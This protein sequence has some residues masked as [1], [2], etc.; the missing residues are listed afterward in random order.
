MKINGRKL[1]FLFGSFIALIIVAL[2]VYRGGI[3]GDGSLMPSLL[4]DSDTPWTWKNPVTSGEVS[5]PSGWKQTENTVYEDAL[6]TL[7]HNSGKSL[8]YISH[9]ETSGDMSLY[10]YVA[11][12][13][14]STQDQLGIGQ[15]EVV[16]NE[17]RFYEAE[18][19]ELFG[20]VVAE[21]RVRIWSDGGDNF[22][23]SVTITDQ[24]YKDLEY[25]AMDVVELLME[26]TVQK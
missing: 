18:G 6:L 16:D 1:S 5:I 20:K 21:T 14:G 15:F 10:E 4:G 3:P 13:E 2:F 22:W 9:K 11:G 24:D 23:E 17:Y 25:E 19:A 8:V 7:T 26:T 12:M